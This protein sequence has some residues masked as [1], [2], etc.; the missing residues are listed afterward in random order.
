M[1]NLKVAGFLD[2]S[3]SVI[4]SYFTIQYY[5]FFFSTQMGTN[6]PC[7]TILTKALCFSPGACPVGEEDSGISWLQQLAARGTKLQSAFSTQRSCQRDHCVMQEL[8]ELFSDQAPTK[9]SA[10]LSQ[11]KPFES[12]TV[13]ETASRSTRE[14]VRRFTSSMPTFRKGE[15]H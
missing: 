11:G 10:A 14:R 12:L 4:E 8:P 9:S 7:L 15:Y 6:Y 13:Q 5:S 2:N 1:S 3:I